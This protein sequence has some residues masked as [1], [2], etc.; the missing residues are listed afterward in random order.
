MN[1][2]KPCD[3]SGDEKKVSEQELNSVTRTYLLEMK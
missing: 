2:R 3:Y 1:S